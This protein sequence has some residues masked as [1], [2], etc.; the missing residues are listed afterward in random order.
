VCASNGIIIDWRDA[1]DPYNQ[2]GNSYESN[3]YSHPSAR[4]KLNKIIDDLICPCFKQYP[5]LIIVDGLLHAMVEQNPDASLR[6]FIKY[7]VPKLLK[8]LTRKQ[9]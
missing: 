7:N 3:W 2:L 8:I 9:K 4:G 5:A 1:L 6:K